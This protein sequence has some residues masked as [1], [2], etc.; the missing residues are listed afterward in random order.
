M[1]WVAQHSPHRLWE[2]TKRDV[3]ESGAG[4]RPTSLEAR[5]VA[6]L[7]L[8]SSGGCACV[9]DCWLNN[10]SQADLAG[11]SPPQGSQV[12]SGDALIMLGWLAGR[13]PLRLTTLSPE[14]YNTIQAKSGAATYSLKPDYVFGVEQQEEDAR[15]QRFDALAQEH[16]VITCYH[17][18]ALEN[19]HSILMNGFLS[20]FNKAA[21]YGEGTYFSSDLSVCMGFIQAG[22]AWGKSTIGSKLSCVAVCDVV[23]HPSVTLPG[24]IIERN[25]DRASSVGGDR[26]PDTYVVV[27]NNDHIR[28]K[29]LFVYAE[30][31]AR[32]GPPTSSNSRRC[33]GGLRR[34]IAANRFAFSLLCYALML[35]VVGLWNTRSVRRWISRMLR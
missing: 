25:L 11:P 8:C 3:S 16:G 10:P 12:P 7:V 22:Q 21:L 15:S 34:V 20:H 18:T 17:G 1:R 9:T 26:A 30:Q 2:G 35:L 13:C 19:F 5:T 32:V 28:I 4:G 23:K 6:L 33:C 29:Y 27:P 31:Q 14:L 24:G